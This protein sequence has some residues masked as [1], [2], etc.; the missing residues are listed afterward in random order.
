[1]IVLIDN[2]DSFTFNLYHQLCQFYEK[3]FVYPHDKI[4][5]KELETKAI[6]ALILSPGPGHP[7]QSGA[8]LEILN[9]YIGK[10]PILGICLGMQ[11]IAC[12]FGATYRK[13]PHPKHGIKSLL[14]YKPEGLF[15]DIKGNLEV[16][17]YH[18]LEIQTN[19]LFDKHFIINAEDK[20]GVVMSIQHKSM[21]IYGLQFHPESILTPCGN[22]IIKNFM[23]GLSKSNFTGSG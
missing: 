20:E 5:S 22:Q 9:A 21:P 12:R 3:V 15:Q 14:K 2:Y 17:R 1:M 19:S 10:V 4:T 13:M 7:Y 23:D 6:K 11:L 16:A 18:S 8:S